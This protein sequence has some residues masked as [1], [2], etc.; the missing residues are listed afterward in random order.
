VCGRYGFAYYEAMGNIV[1]GWASA[2]KGDATRGLEQLRTGLDALGALGAG[3][4]LPYYFA[5]LAETLSRAGMPGEALA[6]L[7]KFRLRC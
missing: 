3:L 7:S 4:R 1:T 6:S 5:L 2:A